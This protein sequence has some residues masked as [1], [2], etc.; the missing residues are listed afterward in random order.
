MVYAGLRVSS[1]VKDLSLPK[2]IAIL[3]NISISPDASDVSFETMLFTRVS[4][5]CFSLTLHLPE[6]HSR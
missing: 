4:C 1:L 2:V 6:K 5:F 3:T